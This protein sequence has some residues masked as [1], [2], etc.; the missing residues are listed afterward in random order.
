MTEEIQVLSV[1]EFMQRMGEWDREGDASPYITLSGAS[2]EAIYARLGVPETPRG[3]G[4]ATRLMTALE[5]CSM[6]VTLFS[7]E[8][9]NGERT[10]RQ[11]RVLHP[12]VRF[13]EE[14][15]VVTL[16]V[17]RALRRREAAYDEEQRMVGNVVEN[18]CK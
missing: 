13:T 4:A 6:P 14:D 12:A 10:V 16:H 18:I 7:F 2:K 5:R 9:A 3:L 17:D 11:Q 15:G 1:R 8:E